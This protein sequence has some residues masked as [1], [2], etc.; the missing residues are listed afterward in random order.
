MSRTLEKL[1]EIQKCLRN[2]YWEGQYISR[3]VAK[4]DCDPDDADVVILSTLA[5]VVDIL[6]DEILSEE[7]RERDYGGLPETREF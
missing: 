6:K 7:R 5:V 4:D 2:N 3:M 1:R